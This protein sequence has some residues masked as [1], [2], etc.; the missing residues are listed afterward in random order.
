[1]EKITTSPGGDL[2]EKL[3]ERGAAA[4]GG[5]TPLRKEGREARRLINSLLG[6]SFDREPG[7]S[8]PPS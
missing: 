4:V 2:Q 5:L 6:K 8:R 1:M 3:V 7:G